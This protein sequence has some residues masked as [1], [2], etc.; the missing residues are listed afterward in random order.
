MPLFERFTFTP[1]GVIWYGAAVFLTHAS[2]ASKKNDAAEK[3]RSLVD[4]SAP[5]V[6]NILDYR[7]FS[8]TQP[9]GVVFVEQNR[10][11]LGQPVSIGA[12]VLFGSYEQDNDHDDGKEQIEWKV[13]D[14][15]D[16]KALLLS[17]YCLN[18][19][20]YHTS[21]YSV[22]WED[23]SLRAWLN[24]GFFN[25]AFDNDEKEKIVASNLRNDENPQYG[26]YAGNDTVDRVF[27][28][29]I[30]EARTFFS[31]DE[32]RCALS[33]EYALAQ[34]TWQSSRSPISPGR[35]SA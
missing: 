8:I 19:Q 9:K 25:E 23:C 18:C 24:N 35:T 32:E 3:S 20:P 28:L 10:T 22:S 6:Y 4:N 7:L 5:I 2:K 1:C 30:E 31:S 13:L 16:G 14:A 15:V 34:S 33:P 21:I 29:S 27:L 12:E 26:T 17:K 11:F